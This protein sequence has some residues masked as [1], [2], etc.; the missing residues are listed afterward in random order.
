MHNYWQESAELNQIAHFSSEINSHR[1]S[2][3]RWFGMMRVG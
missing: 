2:T 1:D 3:E